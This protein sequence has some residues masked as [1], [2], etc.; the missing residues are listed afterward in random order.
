MVHHGLVTDVENRD[1][2][3][4]YG[5]LTQAS[6]NVNG[7]IKAQNLNGLADKFNQIKEAKYQSHQ[8]EP[9]GQGLNR[10][11]QMPYHI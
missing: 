6:E 5:K 11:Y 9:L 2:N 8:R 3:R 10:G 1:R 7:V 4:T